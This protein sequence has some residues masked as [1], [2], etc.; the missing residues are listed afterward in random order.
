M[1]YL[2][3]IESTSSITV[4]W[5]AAIHV[6]AKSPVLRLWKEQLVKTRFEQQAVYDR[7]PKMRD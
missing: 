7:P 3:V 5:P 1:A 4:A 6:V 2:L